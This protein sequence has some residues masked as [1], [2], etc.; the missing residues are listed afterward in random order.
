VKI[1]SYVCGKGANKHKEFAMAVGEMS[2]DEF[3]HFL[4]KNFT[5]LKKY[6]VSVSVWTGGILSI[7]MN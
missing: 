4:T 3:T 5:L 7:L 2:N 6:S 1:D